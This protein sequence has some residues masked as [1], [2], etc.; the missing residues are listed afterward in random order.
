MATLWLV[1]PTALPKPSGKARKISRKPLFNLAGLQDAIHEGALGDDDVLLATR[2]CNKGMQTLEWAIEDL[3]DCIQC[4]CSADHRGAHWCENGA[5]QWLACD[6]YAI[7]YDEK[8]RCRSSH[9]LEFY[10]KFSIDEDGSLTLI[11]IS[12]HLS[13]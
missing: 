9:G 11:M 7:H 3:L 2:G 13:H 1:D 6:A 5:G 12:T 10:L 4:L 8:R